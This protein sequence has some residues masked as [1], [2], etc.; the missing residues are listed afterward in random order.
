MPGLTAWAGVTQL[1]DARAGDVLVVD[2]AAGAVGGAAGQI[3]TLRGGR[4]VGIAGGPEKCA[5]VR[6]IYG[7]EACIDYRTPNWTDALDEA[8]PA[9]PTIVFENVGIAMLTAALQRAAPYVRAILC[10]LVDQYHADAPT[11][12]IP[13]ALVI[14]K[15]AWLMGLVVYD[16]Y[17]RWAEFLAE[18]APWVRDGK[19]RIAEDLVEGLDQAPAMMER[20][21]LGTNVGKCIV[22]VTPE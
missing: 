5:L 22:T 7:F 1:A 10:G 11:P 16:F 3:A 12:Q 9:A 13:A 14:G 19:L 6:D 15:R 17:S 2:A 18:A 20:L 4:A 21:M 8:L